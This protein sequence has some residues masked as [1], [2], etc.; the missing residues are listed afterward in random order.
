MATGMEQLYS[1][2]ILDHSRAPHGRGL[3]ESSKFQSHQMNP[4]CGDEITLGV[5]VKSDPSG[6][7]IEAI[8]WNGVGC[9]IS[10]A[11]ASVMTEELT[12]ASVEQARRA[13]ERFLELMHSRGVEL[14]F[15]T[16]EQLGDAAAFSGVAKYPA[17]IK[18][19]LLGW[20]ALHDALN[21]AQ[22]AQQEPP[23]QENDQE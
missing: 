16:A 5:Q 13:H 21:R 4:I 23:S 11:S 1:E 2:I 18:C 14:D 9:S 6:Q 8:T 17:R 12:G 7:Q 3:D 10:M 20:M 22:S 19:A 15:E